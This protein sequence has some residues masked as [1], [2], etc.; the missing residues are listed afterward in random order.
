M[1]DAVHVLTIHKAKGLEYPA[2]FMPSF[3]QRRPGREEETFVD[4]NLYDVRKCEGTDE[5]ERRVDIYCDD[6]IREV[7]FMSSSVEGCRNYTLN[8]FKTPINR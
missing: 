2:V 7:S 4:R 3:E 6:Q 8:H 5:D 1:M